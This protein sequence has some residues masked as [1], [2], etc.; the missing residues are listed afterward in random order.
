MIGADSTIFHEFIPDQTEFDF[1]VAE[2]VEMLIVF[3]EASGV[4]KG[5]NHFYLVCEDGNVGG[6]VIK[7]KFSLK[8]S[9]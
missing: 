6:S 9:N 4:P 3:N 7:Y 1:G 5:I 8:R 2:R